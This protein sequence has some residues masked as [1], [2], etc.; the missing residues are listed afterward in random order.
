[1]LGARFCGISKGDQ[2]DSI[3]HVRIGDPCTVLFPYHTDVYGVTKNL[4]SQVQHI[5]PQKASS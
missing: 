3:I 1:M 4:P 2:P 5:N